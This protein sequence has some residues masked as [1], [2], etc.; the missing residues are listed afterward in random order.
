M[1][2]L[3]KKAEDRKPREYDLTLDEVIVLSR[4]EF[5]DL[6]FGKFDALLTAF[7]YGF[8]LGVRACKRG[9]VKK[10]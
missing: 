7:H 3:A 8:A 10:I 5:N 9:R 4:M 1:V 2:E 6:R